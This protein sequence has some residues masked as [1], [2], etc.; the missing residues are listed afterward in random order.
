MQTLKLAHLWNPWFQETV[1]FHLIT[2]LSKKKI[3]ITSPEKADLLIIGCYN[4][5]TYSRKIFNSIKKRINL[6]KY[7]KNIDLL[8]FRSYQPLKIFYCNEFFPL[9]SYKA[10]Y[11]ISSNLYVHGYEDKH[12]RF[13]YWKDHIDWSHED[14][15]R[16]L[17]IGNAKRFGFFHKIEDLMIPQGEDFLKKKNI[18][19]FASHLNEPRKSFYLHFSKNF[20]VDGYG[21]YFD[22]S[23]K[24]HNASGYKKKD[25]M[26]NYAFNL[27][28]ENN[29]YPG[30]Y[31]EKILDSFIGKCL[32]ISWAD[33]NI[34]EEFNNKAFINLNV[35]L[36]SDWQELFKSL[37]D[38]SFLRKY[39]KEPLLFKKPSLN[40][41][42]KFFEK[43]LSNL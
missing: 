32:P 17:N 5:N 24:N 43:I 25:I 37:K 15:N 36:N 22:K 23:I 9:D 12:L 33:N 26:K 19:I 39:T 35:F 41:E 42:K 1:L 20:T 34:N 3:E 30:N 21:P 10:D 31:T 40:I 29:M 7:F 6:E 4:L 13:P 16:D 18:C 27:C 28:P 8:S 14:I 2:K 11:Y 38:E